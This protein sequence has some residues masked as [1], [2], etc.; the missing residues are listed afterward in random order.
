[1]CL[2]EWFCPFTRDAL[3]FRQPKIYATLHHP[4]AIITAQRD[5]PLYHSAQLPLM[6]IGVTESAQITRQQERSM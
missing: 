2:E 5:A 1:M 6:L 3:N 4:A